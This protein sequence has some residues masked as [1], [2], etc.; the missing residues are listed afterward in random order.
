MGT[1]AI[2]QPGMPIGEVLRRMADSAWMVLSM[3]DPPRFVWFA[4]PMVTAAVIAVAAVIGLPVMR[5][6]PLPIVLFFAA[7]LTGAL[8]ARGVAYSGRFST[9][10]I[11][12]ACAVTINAVA[13]L[14]RGLQL[15]VAS[16]PTP[17]REPV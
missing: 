3:N 7:G 13:L 17:A 2:W 15:E 1:N 5:D 4:T 14:W 10:M 16:K 12:I 11:G 8:V 9:I 6:M